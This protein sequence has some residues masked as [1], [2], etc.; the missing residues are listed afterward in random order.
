MRKET[1]SARVVGPNTPETDR[2]SH[3][4]CEV[5]LPDG[6]VVRVMATDPMD[7]IEK[8]LKKLRTEK[9]EP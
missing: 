4:W 2:Q 3:V 7:A 5:R 9:G 1:I 8:V 6:D